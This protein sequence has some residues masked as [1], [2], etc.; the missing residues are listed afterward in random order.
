MTKNIIA[1]ILVTIAA[2]FCFAED[3]I[4]AEV[5]GKS[6]YESDIRDR[7][8]KYLEINSSFDK[9]MN[10]DML[11]AKTKAE[12]VKSIILGD[13]ILAEAKKAKAHEDEEYK[14]SLEFLKNQLMQ[15]FFVEKLVTKE[16]TEAKTQARYKQIIAEYADKQEYK[17]SHILVSDEATAKQ[18]K[19]KLNKGEDFTKLAKEYSLD[20]TNKESGGSLDYFTNGQMVEPFEKAVALLKVGEI[21][22]IVK[23]EFG[24]HIIKL[25][26]KRKIKVPSFVELKDRISEELADKFIKEYIEK[27]ET[28]N[29][30]KFL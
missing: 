4:L 8:T 12:I 25:E 17:V 9:N 10:Y 7:I 20:P 23:T 5:N 13:L 30:I 29:K 2:Q 15:K 1:F 19:D 22:D 14:K 11:D 21:S 26:D 3:K 6:V 16:V 18:I 24:Y 27:L 28:E